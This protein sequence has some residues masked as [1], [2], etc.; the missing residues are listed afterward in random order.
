MDFQ[1]LNAAKLAR[2]P[3]VTGRTWNGPAATEFDTM[4]ERQR[5][6]QA[7]KAGQVSYRHNRWWIYDATGAELCRP[8]VVKGIA[9]YYCDADA[10]DM[11][12]TQ[13]CAF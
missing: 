13:R 11:A 5:G 4:D 3:D 8:D 9:A 12:D 2:T 7:A 6:Y 1:L 10:R